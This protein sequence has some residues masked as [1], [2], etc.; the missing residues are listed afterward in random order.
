VLDA[1]I[2]VRAVLGPRVRTILLKYCGA[3]QFMVPDTAFAEAEEHVPEILS[4]RSVAIS[5]GL[6]VFATFRNT[7]VRII[8]SEI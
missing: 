1:N 5:D 7:V 2:L 8:G 4:R 6:E 3:V